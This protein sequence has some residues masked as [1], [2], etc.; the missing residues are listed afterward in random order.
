MRKNIAFVEIPNIITPDQSVEMCGIKVN[1]ISPPLDIIVCYRTPGLT[2]SQDDW[3]TIINNSENRTN[4]LLVGDF[5][6]HN[7]TWNCRKTDLNGERLLKSLDTN[8]LFL[9]ISILSHA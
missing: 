8:E 3:N 1:S 9:H 6:A 5:N 4:C 2:L 7:Q